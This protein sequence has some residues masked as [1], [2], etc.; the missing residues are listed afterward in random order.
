M[1]EHLSTTKEL[2]P[3][4][5]FHV[6]PADFP[7]LSKQLDS[8]NKRQDIDLTAEQYITHTAELI[9]VLDGSENK[10]D[11]ERYPTPDHVIYLDK[12]A[13]PV[14][15]LVNI[16]WDDLAAPDPNN[17]DQPTPRPSH[18]FLNIDRVNWFRRTGTDIDIAGNGRRSDGTFG[19]LGFEDFDASKVT[20]EDLAGL[21]ALFIKEGVD[22]TD[23]DTIFATPT[24]LDGK[25]LLI[26]DEVKN[27]GSTMGIAMHLLERAIPELATTRGE[28]F[29][30]G[31]GTKMTASGEIQMGSV[32]V[33]YDSRDPYGRGIG[34][35]DEAYHHQIHE[36]YPG[37]KTLARKLGAFALS[38]PHHDSDNNILVDTKA[39]ELASEFKLLAEEFREGHVLFAP[40][41]N[42][43]SERRLSVLESQGFYPDATGRFSSYA[44]FRANRNKK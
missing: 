24:T 33:W 30:D 35:V 10:E 4:E 40:P 39:R 16:L 11:R 25:N 34:D 5:R 1:S 41:L 22:T 31:S 14:S 18:S 6:N 23:P 20:R 15:W 12:S 44:N 43:T 32:P 26:V 7:I 2:S 3:E 29:W 21:R 37:R 8:E 17:P 19:R 13:R 27:S 42:Y 9:S 38:A 36:E 28:Y